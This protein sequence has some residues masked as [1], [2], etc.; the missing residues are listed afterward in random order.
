MPHAFEFCVADKLI[1]LL[2]DALMRQIYPTDH[3]G[4]EGIL[5][6]KTQQPASFFETVA[7]LDQN[8]F[9]NSASFQYRR[10]CRRQIIL[11]KN[12]DFRSHPWII[13][14]ANL[15]EVLVTINKAC[16]HK[17]SVTE[18]R[19]VATGSCHATEFKLVVV[20]QS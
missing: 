14:A 1:Q 15:P 16:R 12:L 20:V 6:R 9:F 17:S 10:Q 7:G 19:A 11:I 3:A 5:I 18:P 8:C 2:P 4:D 13:E